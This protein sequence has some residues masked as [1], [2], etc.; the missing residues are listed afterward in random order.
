MSLLLCL[1]RLWRNTLSKPFLLYSV[2]F[3]ARGKAQS[4]ERKR[5][6]CLGKEQSKCAFAAGLASFSR[7]W[8]LRY[9]CEGVPF[10]GSILAFE[11]LGGTVSKGEE[12]GGDRCWSTG[13]CSLP[14][15]TLTLSAKSFHFPKFDYQ[16]GRDEMYSLVENSQGFL[17]SP[18]F[19]ET[20]CGLGPR[21]WLIFSVARFCVSTLSRLSTLVLACTLAIT[22]W[23]LVINSLWMTL[24][25]TRRFPRT[26]GKVA[27]FVY[28]TTQA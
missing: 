16:N 1:F 20:W 4:G 23:N 27:D 24:L 25:S 19:W 6:S 21:R 3:P 17:V 12:P 18:V 2:P 28:S 13:H 8:L 5:N 7:H 26:E 15:S 11:I 9:L 14:S 22:P 10:L